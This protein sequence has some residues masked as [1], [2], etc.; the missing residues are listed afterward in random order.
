[1]GEIQ[2]IIGLINVSLCFKLLLK[3][4]R[5]VYAGVFETAF[6]FNFGLFG[7]KLNMNF[8]ANYPH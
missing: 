3:V 8:K 7:G 4:F 2:N 6:H 5:G 1:M